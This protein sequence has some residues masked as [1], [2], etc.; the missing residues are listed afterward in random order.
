MSISFKDG[1]GTFEEEKKDVDSYSSLKTQYKATIYD[2]KGKKQ[3]SYTVT[4]AA[5]ERVVLTE[6]ELLTSEEYRTYFKDQDYSEAKLTSTANENGCVTRLNPK[7]GKSISVPQPEDSSTSSY[8]SDS[9]TCASG[10]SVSQDGGVVKLTTWNRGDVNAIQML[11]NVKTGKAITFSGIDWKS[12]DSLIVAKP[13]LIVGYD[14]DDGKVIG[15]KP[16]S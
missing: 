13:D 2:F 14:K 12:G 4:F 5:G 3:S 1:W 9:P 11:M 8:D 15:F 16:E 7:K 6:E 10:V